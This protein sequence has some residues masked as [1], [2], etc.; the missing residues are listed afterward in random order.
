[1]I[2]TKEQYDKIYRQVN[3]MYHKGCSNDEICMS[4]SEIPR[5]EI[6]PMIQRI[7]GR[8]MLKKERGSH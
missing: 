7:F 8:E 6:I 2:K 1:M 4:F 5:Y 3:A